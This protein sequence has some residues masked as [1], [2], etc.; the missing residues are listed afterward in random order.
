MEKKV[1]VRPVYI[2]SDNIFSPLGKNTSAN[3]QAICK[4]LSGIREHHL[5]MNPEP[6]YA[7]LFSTGDI[8]GDQD[9]TPFEQIVFL[10]AK[11]AMQN[12]ELD[13]SQSN[14]KTGFILSTT[15]G[16]ICLIENLPDGEVPE[17]RISLNGSASRISKKLGFQSEPLVVS[18]ACISG[19]LAMI[20]GMRLIQSGVFDQVIISGADLIT[21]F[22]FSG[23]RSFQAISTKPCRPFDVARDGISL[24][25]AA[26][27]V[28]LSANKNPGD[29]IL[30][31]GSVSNDANHISGPSRTGEELW[32]AI[33]RAMTQAGVVPEQ[34]DFISAHGTATRFNDDMEAKAIHLASLEHVPVNSFK[35]YYGHTLG[36]AGIL[37]S[38]LT[39][40][41]MKENILVPTLGFL[42]S[43][44]EKPVNVIKELRPAKLNTCLKTASGFGGCNAAI[45]VIDN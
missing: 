28:I 7:A 21:S 4:G 38:I 27:T 32:L 12:A 24:G 33:G 44:T 15:K 43:G 13:I 6:F 14:S 20:T 11:D 40:H 3:M 41:S 16:N 8:P 18:H 9:L 36:A 45:V 26:A 1:S 25:E 35:G 22:I 42:K 39:L 31:G 34:I 37:E 30:A 10:S 19:L 23:F 5:P 17:E 2:K 29:F